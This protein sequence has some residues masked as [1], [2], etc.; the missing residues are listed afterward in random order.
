[1]RKTLTLIVVAGALAALGACNTT[2]EEKAAA[3]GVA[4]A[5]VAG[6][7][8]AAV[9]AG[10]GAVAGHVQDKPHNNAAGREASTPR[11]SRVRAR[12]GSRGPR[13]V[14]GAVRPC[15]ISCSRSRSW[16]PACCC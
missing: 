4:G 1:M 14:R 13:R 10:A 2:T 8:G 5:V 11:L 15:A 3:G 12:I 7:V 9:G 6:P 16:P